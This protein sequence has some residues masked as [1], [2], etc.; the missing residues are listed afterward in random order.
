MSFRNYSSVEAV[1]NRNS[2]RNSSAG[3]SFPSSSEAQSTARTQLTSNVTGMSRY[4]LN[5]E[6]KSLMDQNETGRN[7]GAPRDVLAERIVDGNLNGNP[8]AS[9][10]REKSN[11]SFI[12]ENHNVRSTMS[13]EPKKNTM[14]RQLSQEVSTYQV[15]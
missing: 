7:D 3:A 1:K 11:K 5:Y 2:S 9:S 4:R 15:R 12:N 13:S 6:N 10:P 14:L 8:L